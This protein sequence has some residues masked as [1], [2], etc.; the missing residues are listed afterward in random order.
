MRFYKRKPNY[1]Y[2]NR[3]QDEA[4]Q[5]RKMAAIFAERCRSGVIVT[6]TK[7]NPPFQ[8]VRYGTKREQSS[9]DEQE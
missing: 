8:V 3:T 7:N 6:P 2:N 1:D 5:N 4:F 9:Q